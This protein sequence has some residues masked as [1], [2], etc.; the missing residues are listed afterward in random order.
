MIIKGERKSNNFRSALPVLFLLALLLILTAIKT[1]FLGAFAKKEVPKDVAIFCDAETVKGDKFISNG[2]EFDNGHTQSKEKVYKGNYSCKLDKTNKIGFSFTVPNPQPGTTYKATVFAYNQHPVK[3]YLAAKGQRDDFDDFF[4]QVNKN[5]S[6]DGDWWSK[7]ELIFTLPTQHPVKNLAVYVYKE[8]GENTVF[9]DNFTL[10]KITNF[11]PETT[12]AFVPKQL[13]IQVD[14]DGLQQLEKT[15]KAAYSK[16]ILEQ[17]DD[18]EIKAKII[19]DDK[20][21]VAK[22]RYKGDWLDHLMSGSPSYRIKLKSN[23]SW[24]HLQTFSVQHPKTRG[25]LR[26]WVYHNFLNHADVLSPRYDF[27]YFKMNEDQTKVMALEEHFTK[28]LVEH[29]LRREGPILKLTEDRF[30]E[31]MKRAMSTRRTLADPD[32]KESA[33]WT[34][35]LKPFKEAKTSKSAA[36]RPEFEVAQN[37]LFQYKYNKKK[38]SEV[39]DI[40]RL[41]KFIVVT[42]ICRAYHALTWHNQRF[43]YNPVTSLLE[44]IGYDGHGEE[45]YFPNVTAPIYAEVVY[46]QKPFSTEPLDRL[47]YDKEFMAHYIKYLYQYTKPDFIKSYMAQ[48]TEPL[49]LRESFV[50]AAQKNYQYNNQELIDRALKI[51][52]N[53]LPFGNSIQVFKEKASGD[54]VLLKIYNA[55]I[56]PLE[57]VGIGK[58]KLRTS[59]PIGAG[60][61]VYPQR[62]DV[63]PKYLEINAPHWVSYIHFK[64]PGLDSV[65]TKRISDWAAPKS[66][67]PRQELFTSATNSTNKVYQE[68]NNVISFP[69]DNYLI[70]NPLVIPK[71]KSVVIKAGTKIKFSGDGFFLSFSPVQLLGDPDAP[72][73]IEST[74][75]QSGSFA[76]IQAGGDSKLRHVIFDGQNTMSY[77]GWNLS[78]AVTFYESNVQ[79]INCKFINN[80]C[81]DAL[82]IVRSKFEVANCS[83]SNIYAD[84]FDSDFSEGNI[85]NG[86]YYKIG[87]DA[88]DFSTCQ[89]QIDGCK[90]IEIG[91]KAISVGEQAKV[92]AK[93]IIVDQA[94][95]GFASK[96]LSVLNISDVTISNSNKGFVAYQKKPEYGPAKIILGNHKIT[97][98]KNAFMI[99]S[100]SILEK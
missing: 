18:S 17:A 16:G 23:D 51:S 41:A 73:I 93:D 90:M 47:F 37:L 95:I 46:T 15:R 45:K 86:Q 49:Q 98:V 94:N 6:T 7:Y 76:V 71:G 82:N 28:N 21:I 84:A 54:S 59:D 11:D 31:G 24:N 60:Q 22:L 72:I 87:N 1:D 61:M 75:G 55:H 5:V 80:H 64:L 26:E 4:T 43:Y 83:F 13:K 97:N 79:V 39:F 29:Q 65:Y 78:G 9:F 66:W 92:T 69:D 81:E 62:Q 32:N 100:E 35:E 25:Y 50:K 27:I 20:T 52:E 58:K 91:D 34:S 44:P 89:I 57:I 30:W 67:T 14:I 77:K 53:I 10:S 33:F 88:L 70:T 42:D 36:L 74:D 63:V 85:I 96:D 2:F 56:L 40:E 12:T 8:D 38:P 99:E 68:E 48:I 3:F 19:D